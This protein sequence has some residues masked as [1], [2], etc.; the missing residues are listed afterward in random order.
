MVKSKN[1]FWQINALSSKHNI[2]QLDAL[3]LY[4]KPIAMAKQHSQIKMQYNL[5]GVWMSNGQK[6]EWY[7]P[8]Q[9]PILKA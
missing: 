3:L 7:L 9:Y 5:G 4:Q 8:N 1:G 6:Q 2:Q